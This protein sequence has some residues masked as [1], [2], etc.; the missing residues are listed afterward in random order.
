VGEARK[1]AVLLQHVMANK[2][3]V[4]HSFGRLQLP[5]T[6]VEL[7]SE[8]RLRALMGA[9]Q[10]NSCVSLNG[11]IGSESGGNG[12]TKVLSAGGSCVQG[13][14]AEIMGIG[15]LEPPFVAHLSGGTHFGQ[16]ANVLADFL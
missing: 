3:F 6:R 7:G 9:I 14:T 8:E 2:G 11:N 4:V 12:A 16:W 10:R 13:C 15:V 5:L 1:G